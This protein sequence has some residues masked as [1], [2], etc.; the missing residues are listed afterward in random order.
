MRGRVTVMNISIRNLE[1]F[2]SVAETKSFAASAEQLYVSKSALSRGILTLEDELGCTLFNRGTRGAALTQEGCDLLIFAKNIVNECESMMNYISGFSDNP[3]G[4]I[5]FGLNDNISTNLLYL[6]MLFSIMARD[7]PDIELLSSNYTTDELVQ[8]LDSGLLDVIITGRL[9]AE[10]MT[11][12]R[13]KTAY[14]DSMSI[15][16]NSSSPLAEKKSIRFSEL[17]GSRLMLCKREQN[18]E[19]FKYVVKLCSDNNILPEFRICDFREI[20][21]RAS[22]GEGVGLMPFYDPGISASLPE[23]VTV[24]IQL[25]NNDF[26]RVI[27]RKIYNKSRCSDVLFD[28]TDANAEN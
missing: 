7:Y 4:V 3:A 27:V 8:M 19:F 12:V 2:V 28:I 10:Q 17:E 25:D 1:Y 9:I 21:L 18:R 23:L 6:R 26:D 22:I 14:T 20:K 11:D 15:L 16:V 13:I 5:R 24:P